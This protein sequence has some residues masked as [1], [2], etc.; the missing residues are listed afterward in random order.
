[1]ANQQPGPT[2]PT[3]R[4]LQSYVEAESSFATGG[5]A[6]PL[7]A[8]ARRTISAKITTKAPTE[9]VEH[10][11]GTLSHLDDAIAMPDT[12]QAEWE[13]YAIPSGTIS[14]AP[15]VDTDLTSGG[16]NKVDGGGSTTIAASPSSTTTTLEV[17]D[18]SSIAANTFVVVNNA[19]DGADYLRF[20]TASD[21]GTPGQLT[22]TPPLPFTPAT[23][24]TVKEG[25]TYNVDDDRDDDEASFQFWAGLNRILKRAQGVAPTSWALSIGGAT[26]PRLRWSGPARRG[27]DLLWT[28]INEGGNF[29][30]GD[31]TL[32]VADGNVVPDDVSTSNPYYLLIEDSGNGEEVVKVTAVSG[33]DLTVVRAQLSTSDV[34]HSDGSTIVPYMPDGTYAG[35]V[36]SPRGGEAHLGTAE[37]QLLNGS[38]T[39]EMPLETRENVHG[40]DYALKGYVSDRINAT[41]ELEVVARTEAVATMALGSRRTTV[42]VLAYV[43]SVEGGF[44]AFYAPK[45]L[46]EWPEL[47]FSQR[48]VRIPLSGKCR[49][50]SGA[51]E[52]YLGFA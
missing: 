5:T 41:V 38:L 13:G 22:V 27:D 6:Y 47:D 4:F 24:D 50:T 2:V 19:S 23:S 15:D 16:W 25:V 37:C 44:A 11:Q 26:A 36:I 30:S 8:G 3:F 51:D 35:S 45:V 14:T 1:M 20:V 28:T 9:D 18:A 39:V 32:T 31:L 17:A 40:D 49:G 7:A 12:C 48:E 33:N 29:S 10:A 46:F 21:L 43:G 42:A 52:V 34:T